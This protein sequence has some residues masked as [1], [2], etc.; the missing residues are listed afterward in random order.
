MNTLLTTALISV[1]GFSSA[2][3]VEPGW[4]ERF[5]AVTPT[6][7]DRG[8]SVSHQ[9]HLNAESYLTTSTV[10]A[11][12]ATRVLRSA[13]DPRL[14]DLHV[15]HRLGEDPFSRYVERE[16]WISSVVVLHDGDVVFEAYPR[17]QPGQ[18]HL[19]W[20]VSKVVTAA[21]VAALV[22]DG[23]IE[24]DRTVGDSVP[25]LADSAWA[26]INVDDV[27]H[28]ASGIG[29]LD[30]DGYQDPSTCIYRMEETLGITADRGYDAGLIEHLN[31]MKSHRAAGEVYEYVSANTNV[32]GLI[33][34]HAVSQPFAT[35]LSEQVWKPIGAESNALL[36]INEDGYSYVS[37][38]VIARLR[39]VARFGQLFVEPERFGVFGK[40]LVERMQTRDGVGF[41]ERRQAALAQRFDGDVPR[42]AAWQ[43]DWIWDDGAMYK[44]GYLGQGLY[45]DPARGLVIAWFGT[46]EDY[47]A[48]MNEM[49]EVSRQIATSG[50][51]PAAAPVRQDGST[52]G[53]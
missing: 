9:F 29:C 44:A 4:R 46:G 24:L 16:P 11:P 3:G 40:A 12:D 45:V 48:K 52:D 28:M 33:V 47:S 17:M 14:A 25:A 5:Q 18:R 35:V 42:R 53:R 15:R 1:L 20:S 13:P 10:T 41:S 2:E 26:D 22:H 43:W 6:N 39:D 30:S 31:A 36:A 34:E 8:G 27:L 19:A 32:L 50:L 7:F 21:T 51:Y 37:G 23:A 38:G 49:P